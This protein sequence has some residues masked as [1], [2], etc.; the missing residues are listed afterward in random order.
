M[1][2]GPQSHYWTV[3]ESASAVRYIKRSYP[4]VRGGYLW[5]SGRPGTADWV[6]RVGALLRA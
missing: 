6:R 4:G 5:E 2:V 1:M 3:E